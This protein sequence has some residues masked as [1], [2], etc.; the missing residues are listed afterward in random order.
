MNKREREVSP[1]LI[2]NI[3]TPKT[4]QEFSCKRQ[5]DSNQANDNKTDQ[6]PQDKK[7]KKTQKTTA[8]N[9]KVTWVI[10]LH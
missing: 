1:K 6:H 3:A 9:S 10:Y 8:P 5:V 4:K 2:C 7:G